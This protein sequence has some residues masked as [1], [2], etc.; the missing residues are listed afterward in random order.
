MID[1]IISFVLFLQNSSFALA[2]A[3]IKD[4]TPIPTVLLYVELIKFIFSLTHTRKHIKRNFENIY[5]VIPPLLCFIVMN[6]I[7][8]WTITV[9]SASYYTVMMQLKILWTILLT[10]I[11]LR[12]RYS[13][14]QYISVIIICICCINISLKEQI[15]NNDTTILALVGLIAETLLSCLCAVYMQKIIKNSF[16][17]LWIRN[18]QM[19]FFSM[20]FYIVVIEYF[21]LTFI[22]TKVGILFSFL[23]AFGGILVALSLFYCGALTKVISTSTSIVLTTICETV[24]RKETLKFTLTCFYIIVSLSVL[25]YSTENMKTKVGEVG[26]VEEKEEKEELIEQQSESKH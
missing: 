12:K 26:E 5:T 25:L 23:G 14:P 24:I 9:V 17:E 6:L 8:Y 20:L 10:Y 19:S 1:F 3:N 2:R 18:T 21:N 15:I 7:S 16:D 13:F 11:V 22:P 4:V